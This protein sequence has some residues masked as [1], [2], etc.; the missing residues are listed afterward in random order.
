MCSNQCND[1]KCYSSHVSCDVRITLLRTCVKCHTTVL[2]RL[3]T[4]QRGRERD[5][6]LFEMAKRG[7]S[8]V[9]FC[10]FLLKMK[11]CYSPL[12]VLR[13]VNPPGMMVFSTLYPTSRVVLSTF[14]E[15]M[16]H[17]LD[18]NSRYINISKQ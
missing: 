3:L 15:D 10:D 9:I 14:V 4:H 2:T 6:E 16:L 12:I 17:V 5:Q 8:V 11:K 13:V 7:R 18:G 1:V